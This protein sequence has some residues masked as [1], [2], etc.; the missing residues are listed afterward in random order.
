MKSP[1]YISLALSRELDSRGVARL[2]TDT[3][4][5]AETAPALPHLATWTRTW[6][7]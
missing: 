2:R 7:H 4:K 5:V 3:R 6:A 1:A